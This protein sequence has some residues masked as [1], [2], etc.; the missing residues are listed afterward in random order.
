MKRLP[1]FVIYVLDDDIIRYEPYDQYGISGI[2]GRY[3]EALINEVA[4]LFKVKKDGMP[5]KSLHCDYPT[6][7]WVAA[8][9]HKGLAD[10]QMQ[11]KFNLCL[12]SIVK[13]HDNMRVIKLKE[14]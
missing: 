11:G 7:Y 2:Y 8:P 14:I 5:T 3:L 1:K 4:R 6:I 9:L 10:S 12:E 13:K